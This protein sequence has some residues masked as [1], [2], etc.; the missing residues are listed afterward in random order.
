MKRYTAAGLV[1]VAS[2][3]APAQN[4]PG[5]A[6]DEEPGALVVH[7]GAETAMRVP[8]V[9]GV[10]TL[11]QAVASGAG[12]VWVIEV[13]PAEGAAP[14]TTLVLD[15]SD[16]EP[17]LLER[18]EADDPDERTELRSEDLDGDGIPE[19]TL[20]ERDPG[21]DLCGDVAP[22]LG[23]RVFDPGTRSLRAARRPLDASTAP[24]L[25]ASPDIVRRDRTAHDGA[26]SRSTWNSLDAVPGDPAPVGDALTDDDPATGWRLDA[27]VAGA[28]V[29]GSVAPGAPLIAV[30]AAPLD[31]VAP[32]SGLVL[33]TD[34]GMWRLE[35]DINGPTRWELP[36][37]VRTDCIAVYVPDASDGAIGLGALGIATPL[38]GPLDTLVDAA[39]DIA[40]SSDVTGRTVDALAA[41]DPGVLTAAARGAQPAPRTVLLRALVA[42]DAD[43]VAAEA[44]DA[45]WTTDEL[46]AL[47][48]GLHG[49]APGAWVTTVLQR[50]THVG[51]RAVALDALD[52]APRVD[53]AAVLAM[54][55]AE[56]QPRARALSQRLDAADLVRV[57]HSVDLAGDSMRGAVLVSIGAGAAWFADARSDAEI[58]AL[59]AAAVAHDN[60]SVARAGVALADVFDV[61]SLWGD[62]A[63]MAGSDPS[64]E[65]RA[66]GVATIASWA[67][68]GSR[69]EGADDV[70]VAAFADESATVRL[71]AAR[72][73]PDGAGPRLLEAAANA[74]ADPWPEVRHA[75]LA[76]LARVAPDRAIAAAS[77][78]LGACTEVACID[79]IEALG[80]QAASLDSAA[81]LSAADR[82][83]DAPGTVW[84]LVSAAARVDRAAVAAWAAE[85]VDSQHP[86]AVRVAA[87]HHVAPDATARDELAAW[88]VGDDDVLAT[89]ALDAHVRWGDVEARN[90]LAAALDQSD[91]PDRAEALDAALRRLPLH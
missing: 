57:L 36:A 68:R 91:D 29:A 2:T 89:A 65:L 14:S 80:E 32:P 60:G 38:D 87:A 4:E 47:A 49:H 59:A 76:S 79:I 88:L 67:H 69:S 63:S 10:P 70:L 34:A 26:F 72:S 66:A 61:T 18:I 71:A 24:T 43:A 11:R 6:L 35:G 53:A 3:P 23:L 44:A 78:A 16:G 83:G 62:L 41:L 5:L 82:V 86:R 7:V 22:R 31:G 77:E 8:E 56:L 37:P 15:T 39:R 45:E 12:D 55:L 42:G 50:H 19:L 51:L 20:V 33:V 54:S 90:A 75:A 74:V 13:R 1:L 73:L 40:I 81:L 17:R 48:D 52:R 85:H 25:E 46:E 9:H 64:P 30:T 84:A 58:D 28:W 21:L 27:G